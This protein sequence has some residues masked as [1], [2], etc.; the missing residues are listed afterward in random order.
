MLTYAKGDI[1][2]ARKYFESSPYFDRTWLEYSLVDT[3][4]RMANGQG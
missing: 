3:W 2:T 1:K 4:R